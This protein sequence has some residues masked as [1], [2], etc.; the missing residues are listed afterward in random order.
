[1]TSNVLVVSDDSWT[2]EQVRATLAELDGVGDAVVVGSATQLRAELA[3]GETDVVLVDERLDGGTGFDV[4]RESGLNHPLVATLVLVQRATPEA[5]AAAM[6]AGA[7]SI[8]AL[9][10]SLEQF[11]ARIES[12]VTWSRS[13]RRQIDDS[14]G[15]R[16]TTGEVVALVG[17]KGGVGTSLLTLLLAKELAADHTTCLVDLD[18]RGGDLAGYGNIAVR[19]S[20]VDLVEVA[21]ELT[22]R[23]LGEVTYA[24][25]HRI[26]LIPAPADGEHGEELSESATR[27]IIQALRYQY[28]RVVID[29]G[30][31]LDDVMVMGLDSADDVLVVATPDVPALRAARRLSEAL[32]RLEVRGQA[33]LRMLLNMTDRSNEIQPAMAPKLSGI[34]VAQSLPRLGAP[35]AAAMNTATVLEAKLPELAKPLQAV[36]AAT[37]VPA[38]A[39]PAAPGAEEQAP[40][41]RRRRPTG[42]RGRRLDEDREA[43]QIVAETPVVL[44]LATLVLL[45]CLQLIFWG[46]THIFAH[47]AAQEAARGFAVGLPGDKVRAEVLD[48]VPG[49]WRADV[50]ISAPTVDDVTVTLRTPSPLSL[51]ETSATAQI[52][53]EPGAQDGWG[54]G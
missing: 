48:R 53:W 41:R 46:V 50:T 11:G 6:D 15:H 14:A 25:P 35:L 36:A 34:P 12:A 27:Q 17:A 9:P 16:G 7:R 3:L 20:V 33:P 38:A 5:L 19:R 28:E 45:V 13:V 44:T 18:A 30:S 24:L 37:A 49:P 26:S 1:M 29:C 22:G 42:R 8:L 51:P 4:A 43:G 54:Q 10:P 40:S 21:D 31:R 32:D 52:L 47:N 2:V 39:A 23:A